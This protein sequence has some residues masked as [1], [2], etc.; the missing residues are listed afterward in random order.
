MTEDL[1]RDFKETLW[2]VWE[3]VRKFANYAN[4]EEAVLSSRFLHNEYFALMDSVVKNCSAIDSFTPLYD[5]SIN[6]AGDQVKEKRRKLIALAVRSDAAAIEE[7]LEGGWRYML[8]NLSS[9]LRKALPDDEF[10][11]YCVE[12][13]YDALEN[14][15]QKR[16][17]LE[18]NRQQK[19]SP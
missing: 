18:E 17:R 11:K 15:V 8:Q 6:A 10:K 3:T 19:V 16:R 13:Y 4:I 2:D 14:V 12:Q 7:D 5:V 1:I 9:S